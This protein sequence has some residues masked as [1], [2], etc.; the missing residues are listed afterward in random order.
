[1]HVYFGNN[2]LNFLNLITKNCTTFKTA[3]FMFLLRQ[4]KSMSII[5][6]Y[7]LTS[8]YTACYT[9]FAY[10]KKIYGR[11]HIPGKSTLNLERSMLFSLFHT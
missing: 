5:T 3:D 8:I 4:Y 9:I 7:V 2:A 1:M 11:V 6:Y 10:R